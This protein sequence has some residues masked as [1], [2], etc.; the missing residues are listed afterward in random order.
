MQ[1]QFKNPRRRP[2]PLVVPRDIQLRI[3]RKVLECLRK[4]EMRWGRD[5]PVPEIDYTLMGK[6]SGQ[7]NSISWVIRLNSILLLEN[8]E[9][10]IN[11]TVP[12]EVA[13]LIAHAVYGNK[14]QSHGA[15]WVYVMEL[16]RVEPERCHRYD[17]SNCTRKRFKHTYICA[18][19][20][21]GKNKEWELGPKRHRK[22]QA[23]PETYYC[24]TCRAFLLLKEDEGS[25]LV[26]DH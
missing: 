26:A 12:H 9:D 5:F 13:H 15:E 3:G 17:T 22:Q 21:D 24:P 16:F 6:A 2:Q 19:Q 23:V 1:Y 7:A 8:L 18:C 14:I 4:A 20:V 10:M 25:E 11:S